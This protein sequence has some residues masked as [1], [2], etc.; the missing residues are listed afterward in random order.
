MFKQNHP[1]LVLATYVLV[2]FI[3]LSSQAW[4]STGSGGSLPWDS[5]IV[6]AMQSFQG[7]VA[8][9]FSVVIFIGVGIAVASGA[10]FNVWIKLLIG[11]CFGVSIIL[12]A[13]PIVTNLFSGA[14]VP[15]NV[16]R[17]L[18]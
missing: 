13:A 5:W 8:F 18:P 4:A 11:A 15:D 1:A 14:V 16:I 17:L 6:R 7:P 2:V 10:E 3:L 9:L 12:G